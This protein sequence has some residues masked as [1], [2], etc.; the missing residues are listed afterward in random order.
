MDLVRWTM[1][2]V[3]GRLLFGFIFGIQRNCKGLHLLLDFG[4]T[5]LIF[6]YS[7]FFCRRLIFI[8][9]I[10]LYGICIVSHTIGYIDEKI[11]YV[12]RIYLHEICMVS[13]TIG[14]FL[15]V[16]LTSS[17]IF[18]AFLNLVASNIAFVIFNLM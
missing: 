12:R 14:Y 9:R 3:Y 16:R 10:I 8:R 7:F 11:S 15:I 5:L 13:H 18:D 4:I 6:S 17:A 1:N 2:T